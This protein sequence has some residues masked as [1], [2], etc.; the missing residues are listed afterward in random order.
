[1]HT[2]ITT[3]IYTYIYIYIYT[4]RERDRKIYMYILAINILT[5][6]LEC[7]LEGFIEYGLEAKSSI[8]GLQI[9]FLAARRDDYYGGYCRA[10]QKL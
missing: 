8:L 6:Q 1:M 4:E 3:Y 7:N 9:V 5:C 10:R 2:Y